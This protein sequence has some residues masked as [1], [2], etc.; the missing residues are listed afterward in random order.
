MIA[1]SST[2]VINVNDGQDGA[3]GAQGPQGVSVTNV[4]PEY[5][6]SDSSSELTG[7][8]SGY[9]WAETK[10]EV[11]AQTYLWTR[12][13]NEFSDNTTNYSDAICDITTTN[14]I[15]NVD[16][17][18]GEIIQKVEQSDINTAI[19]SYDNNTVSTIRNQVSQHTTDISGITSRV[20]SVETTTGS[21]GTRMTAAETQIQQTDDTVSLLA[22][23]TTDGQTQQSTI[24]LTPQMISAV[25]SSVSIQDPDG[26][27]TIIQG[28]RIETGAITTDMIDTDAIKSS[29]YSAPTQST[30]PFSS[31]GTF[32]DLANGNF[33]SPNFV[34]DNTN[35]DAYFSGAVTSTSGTI[36]GW[37]I[38]Q[39]EL[40]SVYDD[41]MFTN[42]R[43]FLKNYNGVGNNWSTTKVIGIDSGVSYPFYVTGAG[44]LYAQNAEINGIINSISGSIGGWEISE[45]ELSSSVE[46]DDVEY[47]LFM[48]KFD[49]GTIL[50]TMN[51]GTSIGVNYTG[52]GVFELTPQ[53]NGSGTITFSYN[54]SDYPTKKFHVWSSY[55]DD[56]NL[57]VLPTLQ[58]N[59][60]YGSVVSDSVVVDQTTGEQTIDITSF[61][62]T[63]GTLYV[64][65]SFTNM[66]TSDGTYTLKFE[67]SDYDDVQYKIVSTET[68]NEGALNVG[69]IGIGRKENGVKTYP[70]YV[71]RRGEIY[72]EHAFLNGGE[73]AGFTIVK[74]DTA[75]MGQTTA[76]G[77]H[78]YP[79]GLYVHTSATEDGVAYEYETG[80][81]G[82]A[83]DAT[84]AAFYVRRIAS[85]GAWTQNLNDLRFYVRQ[86]GYL[87]ARDA[88]IDGTIN[89]SQFTARYNNS[90]SS[91]LIELTGSNLTVSNSS[92]STWI[93]PQYITMNN[94]S[95]GSGSV[96]SRKIQ[97]SANVG[98]ESYNGYAYS[99]MYA[100]SVDVA[101]ESTP[102]DNPYTVRHGRF[103]ASSAGNVG[104]WDVENENW[105]IQSNSSFNINIPHPLTTNSVQIGATTSTN[106][107]INTGYIDIINTTSSRTCRL[108]SADSG[109]IGIYE[110]NASAYLIYSDSSGDVRVPHMLYCYGKN[111]TTQRVPVGS[112]NQSNQAMSWM[113]GTATST[114]SINGQ[115]NSSGWSTKT[116]AVSSSDIRLKKDIEDSKVDA[117]EVINRVKVREFTWKD[118][119][120]LQKIGVVVDELEELDPLLSVGGG[121]DENGNPIY[122]SVN[123]LLMISY[124]TKAVQQLSAKVEILQQEIK[125]LKGDK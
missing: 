46:I 21:L 30:Q 74:N 26:N 83:E 106:T 59:G 22:S 76:N 35:G 112:S 78:V 94:L 57:Q 24:T 34:V 97:M 85:G 3:Q 1:M 33:I 19:S 67:I 118:D 92:Y 2:R 99:Q 110:P 18:N 36:G 91:P 8:G 123:N 12:N 89:A 107:K 75:G 114:L 121:E 23:V 44:K 71:N 60:V 68:I 51:G 104:I 86:N 17:L 88:R 117:L 84:N 58:N 20:S 14:V 100:N 47:S 43:V 27:E 77:G 7:S 116:I 98:Y 50:A 5:R 111:D 115:W 16:Q 82:D 11:T 15:F 66:N 120:V 55:H 95:S 105:I 25:S 102:D 125:D 39:N 4:V 52:D 65:L 122:K 63:S 101:Y 87:Y 109:N 28:G 79:T 69:V 9:T 41:Q 62:F 38:G 80:I 103:T 73:I 6:L 13:R 53:T 54:L 70:F 40:Y 119:N 10:P 81:R 93:A 96:Y 90:S 72:A 48:R 113:G 61:D 108:V 64:S 32:L 45:K 31:A 37:V 42:Y 49:D 29:N 124:L 56:R